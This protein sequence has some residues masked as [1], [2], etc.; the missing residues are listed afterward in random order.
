MDYR[1]AQEVV[2]GALPKARHEVDPS[3]PPPSFP[4][5]SFPLLRAIAATDYSVHL[6]HLKHFKRVVLLQ[7]D[8]VKLGYHRLRLELPKLAYHFL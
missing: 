7:L 3:L 8:Y 1:Q 5:P 4:L 6:D 2:H